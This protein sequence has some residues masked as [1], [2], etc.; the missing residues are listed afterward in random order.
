[1]TD[2]AAH[3]PEAIIP[4]D[5]APLR[6]LTLAMAVMCYLAV[7][8]A[9]G[10]V[11]INRSVEAWTGDLSREITVQIREIQGRNMEDDLAKAAAILKA[12]PGV[13]NVTVL[14]EKA[15]IDL[16]E[17]WIGGIDG[18]EDL[19]VPRLIAIEID[20][21]NPPD[22]AALETALRNEV[23]GVSLDTHKRWQAELTRMARVLTTLAYA[24][25]ALIG[26][27]TI[28]IVV[29]ATRAALE[30]NREVVEVLHLVGARDSFIARQVWGRFLRTGLTAGVIGLV[31]GI[32][33]FFLAAGAAPESFAAITQEFLSFSGGH[34][35]QNYLSLAA[36]PLVVTLICLITSRVTLLRILKSL[37]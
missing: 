15:A 9:G 1:M 6:T 8:A 29:F 10:L 19:P 26:L 27:C 13:L 4:P 16:L 18:L 32:L 34:L 21:G 5:A 24:I 30:A 2:Q 33:T 11:L 22:F 14:D 12:T 17:P 35:T 25:L 20:P 31:L 7:L 36:V 3:R 37:R 23:P 28:A